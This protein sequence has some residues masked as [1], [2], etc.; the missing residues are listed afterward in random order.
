MVGESCSVEKELDSTIATNAVYQDKTNILFSVKVLLSRCCEYSDTVAMLMFLGVNRIF[1]STNGYDSLFLD[2]RDAKNPFRNGFNWGYLFHC[3]EMGIFRNESKIFWLPGYGSGCGQGKSRCSWSWGKHCHGQ[4]TW[5]NVADR[6]C[7]Q[8]GFHSLLVFHL[9][10]VSFLNFLCVWLFL[11][12]NI[13]YYLI[14]TPKLASK[15]LYLFSY[16]GIFEIYM[17]T[18]MDVVE[19]YLCQ[20]DRLFWWD[21]SWLYTVL[22]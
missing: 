20:I 7:K 13:L 2:R 22:T 3:L 8:C 19:I 21:M 12:V 16:Q 6:R 9:Q 1:V 18:G 14:A 4:H 11:Y 17:V 15:V 10:E 5:F